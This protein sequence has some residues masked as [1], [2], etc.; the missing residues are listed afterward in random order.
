MY[1]IQ[2]SDN[3]LMH[4]S[5]IVW[6]N[7]DT[8]KAMQFYRTYLLKVALINLTSAENLTLK[9]DSKFLDHDFWDRASNSRQT[10]ICSI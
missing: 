8:Q 2:S 9:L 3:D 10:R 1:F 7:T 4:M 5:S 6:T